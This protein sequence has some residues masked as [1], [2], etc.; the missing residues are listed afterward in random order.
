MPKQVIAYRCEFGCGRR[1]LLSK[2]G[3]KQHEKIC[4]DNPA[5]RACQTCVFQ[6]AYQY[7]PDGG[8]YLTHCSE[9]GVIDS[10]SQCETWRPRQ[11]LGLRLVKAA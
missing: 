1:A 5:N 11:D 3:M 7:I 8:R 4:F 2:S 10:T 6:D 9:L